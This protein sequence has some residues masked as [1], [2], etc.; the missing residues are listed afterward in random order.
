MQGWV[1]TSNIF[2]RRGG[3]A[4]FRRRPT[5][6]CRGGCPLLALAGRSRHVYR[7]RI[8][9]MRFLK[10]DD[11]SKKSRRNLKRSRTR[12]RLLS[13]AAYWKHLSPLLVSF[14]DASLG[15]FPRPLGNV[16][17]V[18]S[19]DIQPMSA[20][21]ASPDATSALGLISPPITDITPPRARTLPVTTLASAVPI[22]L[23]SI[24]HR[25]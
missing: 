7:G 23:N 4:G 5:S 15:Q 25:A 21:P 11:G 3:T 8:E 22:V 17:H 18:S 12:T 24:M 1:K 2:E 9:L 10:I 14:V 16:Q 20:D 19:G 6:R 13:P